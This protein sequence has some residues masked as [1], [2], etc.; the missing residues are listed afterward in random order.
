MKQQ[1]IVGTSETFDETTEDNTEISK[2]CHRQGSTSDQNRKISHKEDR[3]KRIQ[4]QDQFCNDCGKGF[5]T[6]TSLEKNRYL[7]RQLKFVCEMC[8][9]GFSFISRLKQYQITNRTIAT[10][11]CMCKGCDRMFNNVGELHRHVGQ[12]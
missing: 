9:Q 2:T 3:R 4:G 7:H 12:H 10:L 1:K 6:Q 8:G 5:N 11:P